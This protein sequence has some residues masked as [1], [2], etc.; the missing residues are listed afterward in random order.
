MNPRLALYDLAA[1]HRLDERATRRLATL[2]GVGSESASLV[3]RLPLVVA[4]V[5]AGL[6]GLGVVFWVAAH[7]ESLGRFGRFALLQGVFIVMCAGAL[8]RPAA[9]APLALVALLVVGGLF[10]YFGQTYQ[11]GADA[12]QLFALWAALTLPL[13]IAVRND[14]LWA[15]WSLVAMTAIALCVQA[16]TGHRWRIEPDDWPAHLAGWLAAGV[17]IAALAP[18]ARR[19]S[20]AGAWSFRGALTLAIV[21]VCVTAFGALFDSHV[22]PQYAL[23]LLVLV[24]A[25]AAF[26]LPGRLEI[27]AV[28][29]LAFGIDTLLVAGL[30]WRLFEQHHGDPIGRLFVIGVAAAALLAATVSL[31][32]KL[33][34][35]EA[36][37]GHAQ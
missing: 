26:A 1:Q 24:A 29:A 9:R 12:W 27:Y 2:A 22:S 23:G 18:A 3:R 34:R 14:L 32:L 28:S 16:H 11:T 30:A 31:I 13:A 6:T 37:R 4:M 19:L 17:V 25:A 21:A 33:S 5:A 35:R 15:P 7:W 20:G 36:S 10:A 8:W